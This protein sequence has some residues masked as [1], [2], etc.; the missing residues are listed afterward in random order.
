MWYY[1]YYLNILK[2]CLVDKRLN[3][4]EIKKTK[5]L[6][7]RHF[8]LSFKP[9]TWF[10]SISSFYNL[11]LIHCSSRNAWKLC[12][13]KSI[14]DLQQ[15]LSLYDSNFCILFLFVVYSHFSSLYG[16]MNHSCSALVVIGVVMLLLLFLLYYVLILD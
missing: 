9:V 10:F 3:L 14:F 7:R 5:L 15:C 1:D 4:F 11:I 6:A 8:V 16:H 13:S 12:K 2:I